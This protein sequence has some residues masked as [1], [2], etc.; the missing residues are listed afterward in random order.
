MNFLYKY[1]FAHS[2]LEETICNEYSEITLPPDY[3]ADARY[4]YLK[5]YIAHL[6][7]LSYRFTYQITSIDTDG[8]PREDEYCNILSA[9]EK[10]NLIRK[11]KDVIDVQKRAKLIKEAKRHFIK[12]TL[13]DIKD[14]QYLILLIYVLHEENWFNFFPLP[15]EAFEFVDHNNRMDVV[16]EVYGRYFLFYDYLQGLL[17]ACGTKSYTQA[18]NTS[19]SKRENK[20]ECIQDLFFDVHKKNGVYEKVKDILCSPVSYAVARASEIEEG[21]QFAV[22]DGNTIRWNENVRGSFMYL[23]GLYQVLE[24]KRWI[25]KLPKYY[26]RT[27]STS[28]GVAMSRN[29]FTLMR[30]GNLHD[31]YIKPFRLLLKHI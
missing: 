11:H 26:L 8:I 28:F 29:A 18:L 31:K 25:M 2:A 27:A 23:A 5:G 4:A 21:F 20:I 12:D 17:K 24:D 6:Q 16:G 15:D 13:G 1:T 22:A 3:D 14:E 7:F 19:H 9:L 30:T 10:I